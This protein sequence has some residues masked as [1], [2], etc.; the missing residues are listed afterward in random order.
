MLTI[1]CTGPQMAMAMETHIHHGKAEWRGS[2]G[3]P[4][5]GESMY[6]AG[7]LSSPDSSPS[8]TTHATPSVYQM[9]ITVDGLRGARLNL[10][11]AS[12][13]GIPSAT[14]VSRSTRRSRS[15]ATSTP[16]PVTTLTRTR[17]PNSV[18]AATVQ[19]SIWNAKD[20]QIPVT[21][22]IEIVVPGD[23]SRRPLSALQTT[24]S[25][26]TNAQV[27][28]RTVSHI[29]S[30]FDVT[31]TLNC[32]LDVHTFEHGCRPCAHGRQLHLTGRSGEP[33]GCVVV[34]PYSIKMSV[35]FRGG[36]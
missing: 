33:D 11:R 28:T 6:G 10:R 18:R 34:P 16:A 19:P 5:A 1:M 32:V 8:A 7:N 3:I 13:R 27:R 31:D 22:S 14:A 20:Q 23:R 21:I 9:A 17:M 26:V 12:P 24:M 29:A 4:Q 15:S 2:H 30:P 35:L 36:S 25:P